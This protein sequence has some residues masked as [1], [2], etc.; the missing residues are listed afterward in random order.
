MVKKLFIF[1]L[2]VLFTFSLYSQEAEAIAEADG[3]IETENTASS[4]AAADDFDSI[5]E[6]AQDVEEPVLQQPVN[7]SSVQIFNPAFSSMVHFT[8][9]FSGEVGLIYV[10][11]RDEEE[12]DDDASGFF[13]LKN[14]LNMTVKPSDIFAIKG[15]LDTGISNGFKLDVSSFYFNY[16]LLDTLYISAGK[17]SL[18]WGN[19]RLFNSSY[20]G[21]EKHSVCLYST[22]PR[23]AD[24]FAEDAAP[25]AL[26][27][28]YPWSWGT[29]TFAITG[30]T[31]SN[32]S[33]K[34]KNFNYY[35]S[36]E[37]SVLNTNINIFAKRPQKTDK[38]E[39][40][41][42]YGLEVKRTILGFDTYA[43]G[44]LRVKDYNQLNHSAGYEYI[45]ATAGLYRLFDSFEPNI[46]FNIEYQHEYN[47]SSVKKHY[48]RLAFEGGLKK[49]GKKKN[50]KLGVLSH[51]NIT[52]KHGYSGLNFIVSGILPY[53]EWSNKVAFGYGEKYEI[54][55]CL[56]SSSISLALDY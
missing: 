47:P 38:I 1:L 23:Y 11:M 41:E 31:V 56:V 12:G 33:V 53:A 10:H 27:I 32:N 24:I 52:E 14:T 2:L 5:F 29:L 51:Y 25:L 49:L 9:K 36:L 13:S 21:V 6:S 50:M 44:L 15:S 3:E 18:S 55:V 16:L 30:K 20:Y 4:E 46:G 8:G 22:G 37:L 43:Q 17:K 40:N 19:I 48:D 35:G 39:K 26:D 28:K 34:P 42:L 7:N 45:T 54:P